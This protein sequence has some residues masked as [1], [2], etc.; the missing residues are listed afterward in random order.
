MIVMIQCA[1]S[2]HSILGEIIGAAR[3]HETL[4]PATV[5]AAAG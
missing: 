1:A 5:V 3:V 4:L 2:K